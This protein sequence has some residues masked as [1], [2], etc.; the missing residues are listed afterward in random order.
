MLVFGSFAT[1][2][3]SAQVRLQEREAAEPAPSAPPPPAVAAPPV[4]IVPPQPVRTGIEYPPGQALDARVVLEL[5]VG[6]SGEVNEARAIEGE[7][8]FST[9]AEAAALGW[10]FLPATR[11]GV[12]VAARIRFAVRFEAPREEP[13]SEQTQ[14]KAPEA[15]P[16]ASAPKQAVDAPLEVVVTGERAPLRVRLS[17]AE[18][19]ELPGAFGDPFR[20]IEVLPGVVPILSGVPYYYVRGAPPGNVGYLFDGIPVPVLFHFGAGPG[21]LHPAFV[22]HVD[23]YAGAYPASYGRFAGGI[24]AGEM[25]PPA[26]ALRAE[27]SIRLLD[28]GGMLEAPF[29]EGRGSVMLGGRYSY[30]AAALSLLAPDVVLRYWDYQTRVR[31]ALGPKDSV[32]LLTFGSGDLAGEMEEN[33]TTQ[34]DGS[35]EVTREQETAVDLGF[36]RFDLRWDHR[37]P[38]GNWRQAL[39][40]GL[41]VT[42]FA[43]GAVR[44]LNYQVGVRSELEQRLSPRVQLRAGADVL[45]ERLVQR[46]D[47]DENGID[48]DLA[49]SPDGPSPNGPE[50][51]PGGPEPIPGE[52]EPLPPMAGPS[53]DDEVDFGFGRRRIDISAGIRADLV[54]DVAPGI[55]VVPGL[56]ADLY[57]SQGDVALALD[58]RLS[59]RFK[60]SKGL[61]L[62]HGLGLAHQMPSF[63]ITIPGAKPT[64]KGGLQRAVQYSAGLEY[65]LPFEMQSSLTLFQNLFFNLTDFIGLARLQ[66]IEGDPSNQRMA[67]HAY[68]A[69]LTLRRSLAKRVGFFAAYT[70]SRSERFA[71]ILAGPAT[72]DRT[73]V[74]NLAVSY[75][76][77]RHW[78]VGGRWMFYTGVPAQV[79]YLNAARRPPR[80]PSFNRLDLRLQKRW[81]IDRGPS[82][83]GLV[84]EMLNTTLN[85]EVLQ[86]EC[87]AY[88]CKDEELGPVSIPSIGVEGAL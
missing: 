58:P 3:A 29:A 22:D 17:R 64:L 57:V 61:T 23:L 54:I 30:T 19:Q 71:G 7:A 15:T 81:L 79:A 84:L 6:A 26:F 25:A 77:G 51:I 50:P 78:R 43:E 76:L 70:L 52:P 63:V 48:D 28:T 83:V 46:V 21:V 5:L 59:A 34:P 55:E 18:V 45:A 73:H 20:A 60:L 41:D 62:L 13:A 86:R 36:H 74:L 82:Y 38:Q 4:A 47:Q 53:D 10:R 14:T 85:K 69:E 32:E 42:R 11:A 12:A 2:P 72:T 39:M 66:D 44:F 27:A 80:A 56:R 37:L 67:G 65:Q 35:M 49:P 16:V 88:D 8:P 40:L 9:A 1:T 33:Y 68:G 31:Y 75:D 24:V 87:N